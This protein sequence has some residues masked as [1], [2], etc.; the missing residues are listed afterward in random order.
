MKTVAFTDWHEI[1]ID[2]VKQIAKLVMV[3]EKSYLVIKSKNAKVFWVDSHS[4]THIRIKNE[5]SISD[6]RKLGIL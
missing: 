4:P 6:A 5:M 1:E 2:G 3:E